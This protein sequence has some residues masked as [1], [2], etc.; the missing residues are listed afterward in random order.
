MWRKMY[1]N[2]KSVGQ[3]NILKIS[4]PNALKGRTNVKW[5]KAK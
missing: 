4:A 2:A 5:Y 3:K 1:S